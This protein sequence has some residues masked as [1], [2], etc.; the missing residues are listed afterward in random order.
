MRRIGNFVLASLAAAAMLC[1]PDMADAQVRRTT[2][3]QSQQEKSRSSQTKSSSSSSQRRSTSTQNRNTGSSQVRS[4]S[5]QRRTSGSSQVRSTG[6][7]NRNTGA[8]QVRSSGT[9]NRTSGSSQVRSSSTQN[10]TSGSSQVRNSGSVNVSTSGQNQV[11]SNGNSRQ[12]R[13]TTSGTDTQRRQQTGTVQVQSGSHNVVNSQGNNVRRST[14]SSVRSSDDGHRVAKPLGNNNQ[15]V[16]DNSSSSSV[17]RNTNVTKNGLGT[18]TSQMRSQSGNYSQAN[19]N[20]GYDR[21]DDFRINDY[22]VHRIP[23]RERDFLPYDRPGHFY[24]HGHHHCFG[25]RVEVLP[26]RYEVRRY[27]GVDYYFYNNVYYR[28]YHGHYIVCR[29]PFGVTVRASLADIAFATVNFAYYSNVYRAYSAIDANNRYIDQ[30]NRIIAQ[31]N[32]T[33]MAQNRAI[34]MNP[35]AATSSYEIAN[36]LG[37]VQSY[38]YAD[39]NYYYDD[40]VFYIINDYGE[41]QVIVPPAGALV[42]K[43]PEDYDTLVLN[44]NQYYRVDD[45]VYRLTLVQGTPFLEVLGQMYGNMARTYNIY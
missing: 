5:T 44:N 36:R 16:R 4:S 33:I 34:A 30:Q 7:Q 3:T 1:Q 14:S 20:R 23:P 38:A 22:N 10:R 37:L 43:L 6:T 45:T 15:Q 26:P 27:F 25:F 8:S 32:A 9:Q 2:N 13:R 24:A 12:V 42:Q 18:V 28:P 41:Y 39:K 35:N 11:R 40:G 29:P 19:K 21:S 17:R 31:N